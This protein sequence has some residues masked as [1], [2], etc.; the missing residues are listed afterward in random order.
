MKLIFPEVRAKMSVIAVFILFFCTFF[1]TSAMDIIST[2]IENSNSNWEL[3]TDKVMGG[4]S[5][6][7]LTEEIE[8]G[9]KFFRLEGIVSTKNNGGFIQFRSKSI[10]KENDFKGIRLE[11]RGAVGE[12][13]VH[14]RTN[15][16]FLPWQYYSGKFVV[17]E[18]WEKV[19]IM[20]KD[21]EKSNF[22]QPS[23]FISSEITSIGF[24]AF[25]KDFNAKLDIKSAQWIKD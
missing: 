16:T 15:Y 22:Y 11:T 19:N 14:L 4:V 10:I 2:D 6:G 5:E 23:K 18:S 9:K 17:T 7:T 21:F 1:K 24:V 13:F 12:Y 25:G 20:F 3:I 8:D